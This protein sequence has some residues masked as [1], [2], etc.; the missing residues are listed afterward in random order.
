LLDPDLAERLFRRAADIGELDAGS[1]AISTVLATDGPLA[2]LDSIAEGKN[3][4]LL[5]HFA[6]LAPE[7]VI[8]HLAELIAGSSED[9]LAD[10]T[11]IRRDLVWALGKLAWHSKT[12]VTAAD[13]LLRLAIAENE[14][15]S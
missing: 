13:T 11:E 8:Q 9:V 14:S 4:D 12:F 3:S 15:Y 6:V 2:S 7:A 5:V 1:S 10:A